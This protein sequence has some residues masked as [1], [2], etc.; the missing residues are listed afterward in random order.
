[1]LPVSVRSFVGAAAALSL[2]AACAENAPRSSTISS[3]GPRRAVQGFSCV[4]TVKTKTVHCTSLDHGS[5]QNNLLSRSGALR[6]NITVGGQGQYVQ[7]TSSNVSYDGTQNFS[8]DV[9]IQNLIEQSMATSDG[10]T[11]DTGGIKI[12]FQEAPVAT[13]LVD[14]SGS[15]AISVSNADGTG[16]FTTTNQSFYEYTGAALGVDDILSTNETSSAK[17]WIFAIDPN[18]ATFEFT[19]YVNAAVASEQGYVTLTPDTIALAIGGDTTLTGTVKSAVGDSI[20]GQTITWSSSNTNVATV[21]PSTGLVT[22]IGA[23]EAIITATSTTRTGT[24]IVDISPTMNVGDAYVVS[25]PDAARIVLSGGA[26]G[27]EFVATPFNGDQVNS[28][29]TTTTATGVQAV[30]GGPS[31]DL[32]P[33]GLP[34]MRNVLGTKPSLRPVTNLTL[35]SRFE[36]G[37]RLKEQT[38]LPSLSPSRRISL[39]RN[40][41]P[42]F[43]TRAIKL[44]SAGTLRRSIIPGVVP[45]VGDSMDLNV[46]LGCNGTLDVRRGVVQSVSNRAIVVADTGNPSSGFVQSDYDAIAADFDTVAY[47]VDS[48]N[49]GE[50]TDIDNNGHTVIFYTRAVNELSPPGSGAYTMGYTASRDVFSSGSCNLSNEGEIIYMLVPDISG[51]VNGGANAHSFSLVRGNASSTLV[52]EFQHLINAWRRMYVTGAPGFEEPWLDNGLSNIADELAFFQLA[53][54]LAPGQNLTVSDLTT[55]PNAGARVA[56]FN[57]Y[58]GQNNYV[59]DFALLSSWLQR[60]DTAGIFG[61]PVSGGTDS[62]DANPFVNA[63]AQGATWLFLRYAADRQ[64]GSQSTFWY[65][66][67]NSNLSG[68]ANIQNAIGTD[69]APWFRDMAMAIYADDAVSGVGSQYGIGSWNFRSLYTALGD[70]NF[71]VAPDT[72]VNNTPVALTLK[73]GASFYFR[74]GVA[75]GG[76]GTLVTQSSAALPSN[77][78]MVIVRTQ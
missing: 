29:S 27:E 35:Q 74:F 2:L 13:S 58:L 30:T 43:G 3:L 21:D 9:T 24:A 33:R 75:S 76:F 1:M 61:V 38:V 10:V 51:V 42:T 41:T 66:L 39:S 12:F 7:L 16:T 65:N 77:F 17:T 53:T 70:G 40:V 45:A 19:V 69:P 44:G 57:T 60:P 54:G 71:P 5:T 25:G 73:N 50:P 56:A 37:L 6:R 20:P 4:G 15:S 68:V 78:S 49:F 34:S 28:L 64:T 14:G 36:M 18:V 67:V 52:R 31:P 46:A 32:I 63:S 59:G 23:G 55:G 26:S 72:L 47:R 48:A 22:A 11:P 62:S 8:F